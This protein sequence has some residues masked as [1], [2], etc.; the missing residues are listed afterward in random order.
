MGISRSATVVCAYLVATTPLI[1]SEAIDF[2]RAKRGVVCPNLGFRQQLET[3]GK[4][5]DGEDFKNDPL[6]PELVIDETTG[7]DDPCAQSKSRT[8]KKKTLKSRWLHLLEK[9]QKLD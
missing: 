3:Y 7:V 2:V 9:A 1:P 6:P 5:F 4:Q 8:H